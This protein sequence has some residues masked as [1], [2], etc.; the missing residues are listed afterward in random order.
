MFK[1]SFEP[2]IKSTNFAA[3]LGEG[4]KIVCFNSFEIQPLFKKLSLLTASPFQKQG[5]SGILQPGLMQP[6]KMKRFQISL[7]K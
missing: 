5:Y 3:V 7:L 6:Q 2:I 1:K 4:L